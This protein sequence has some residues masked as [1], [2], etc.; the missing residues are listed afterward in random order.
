MIQKPQNSVQLNNSE[1]AVTLR[2]VHLS[3]NAIDFLDFTSIRTRRSAQYS[4]LHIT[5][6]H[7]KY[8]LLPA[9]SHQYVIHLYS[10]IRSFPEE[11]SAV[12]RVAVTTLQC[13]HINSILFLSI[14]AR[15][16][17]VNNA[18]VKT[19]ATVRLILIT[20]AT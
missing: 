7:F 5:V 13:R 20:Q 11:V 6:L 9:K 4:T 8:Q 17:F 18:G 2:S 10:H 19:K 14:L 15:M 16:S 12:A 3:Y 1:E